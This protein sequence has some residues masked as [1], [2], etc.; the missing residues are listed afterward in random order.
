MVNLPTRQVDGLIVRLKL[1]WINLCQTFTLD[2]HGFEAV[3]EICWQ[4]TLLLLSRVGQ[5]SNK[6]NISTC[7]DVL[8]QRTAKS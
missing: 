5:Y 3:K 6:E 1:A 8:T 7:S 4:K 2:N